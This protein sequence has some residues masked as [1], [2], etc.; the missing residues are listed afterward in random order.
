MIWVQFSMVALAFVTLAVYAQR[1]NAVSFRTHRARCVLAQLAGGGAACIVFGHA[2]L[3][4]SH[5][6]VLCGMVLAACWLHILGT[7][8]AW[9]A[10][11]PVKE[12]RQMPD[13]AEHA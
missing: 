8:D 13:N 12:S 3:A 9:R 7:A 5:E 4:D 6:L 2:F 11:P 1:V 10:G